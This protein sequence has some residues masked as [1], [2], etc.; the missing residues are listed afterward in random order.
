MIRTMSE[1]Q[2]EAVEYWVHR[3]QAPLL[4]ADWEIVVEP[5]PPADH[6]ADAEI[7]PVGQSKRARMRVSAELFAE[8]ILY[9]R[10]VLVHEMVHLHCWDLDETLGAMTKDET[11]GA[12]AQT[13]E[14]QIHVL[15]DQIARLLCSSGLD[16]PSMGGLGRA[17]P[18]D[19][20]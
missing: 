10:Q 7:L 5:D 1:A 14:R 8:D 19:P 9:Q 2:R 18:L 3:A 20:V 12:W 16:L 17:L 6:D 15:V 13:A 4:L 11:E